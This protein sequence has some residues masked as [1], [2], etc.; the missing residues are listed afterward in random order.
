LSLLVALALSAAGRLP[1][2][3]QCRQD[4]SFVEFRGA[5]TSAVERRDMDALLH[6]MSDKVRLSFGG[7]FGK[8][9][10]RHYWEG[11]PDNSGELWAELG[12]AL[13]LGCA[14]KGQARVFPSMFAQA[15]DLDGFETWIARP[16]ARLRRTSGLHGKIVA[17]LSW[18][19]LSLDG[20]WTGGDWI[21]V[22]VLN[23]PRGFVHK[24]AARSPIDYRLIANREGDR[25]LITAF[26]AGD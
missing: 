24:S 26:I 23:G 25:W 19:V 9:E 11:R 18:N 13:A 21:P 8:K 4:L 22:R 12:D 7:R 2:I 17:N 15:D 5:L 1:P 20:E 10:F 14:I 6:L 3:D 16:G